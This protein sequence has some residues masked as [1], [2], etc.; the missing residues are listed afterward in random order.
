MR[1]R[2]APLRA[3]L[4]ELQAARTILQNRRRQTPAKQARVDVCRYGQMYVCMDKCMYGRMY[5]WTDIYIYMHVWMGICMY[6]S[7]C[8]YEVDGWM[9][10]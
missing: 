6:A 5:G 7:I 2:V 4:Q 3:L 8:V 10:G 1:L 9:G